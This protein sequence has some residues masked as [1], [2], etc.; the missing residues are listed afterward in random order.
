MRADSLAFT[1]VYM[2]YE[3]SCNKKF[4][5]T[6][7]LR[8]VVGEADVSTIVNLLRDMRVIVSRKEY[9]DTIRQVRCGLNLPGEDNG[10]LVFDSLSDDGII[11]LNPAVVEEMRKKNGHGELSYNMVRHFI[12]DLLGSMELAANMG[13]LK[14]LVKD[15]ATKYEDKFK[16]AVAKDIIISHSCSL[17]EVE[18]ASLAAAKLASPV[19]FSNVM[20]VLLTRAQRLAGRMSLELT[21]EDVEEY[22][23]RGSSGWT[24]SR[25]LVGETA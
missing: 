4:I 16:I 23:L 25:S 20:T 5:P 10:S 7:E 12:S 19:K 24:T 21:Q 1:I 15:V 9:C 22:V 13:S 6:K 17:S 11:A 18:R 3:A 14:E 2:L 8:D